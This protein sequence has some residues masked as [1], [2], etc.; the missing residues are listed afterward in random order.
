MAAPVIVVHYHELWLKGR[1]RKFFMGKLMLAL[2]R[3]LAD[4]PI[5]RFGQPGDRVLIHL[6]EGADPQ[7]ILA[8]LERVLGIAYMAVAQPVGSKAV[9]A[10]RFHVKAAGRVGPLALQMHN[11]G[12]FDEYANIAIEEN[13]K[14][15]ELI[16]AK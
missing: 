14:R 8:R 4:L 1:N 12:L 10:G 9:E 15:D 13:P 5:R 2:R 6:S 16:T 3:T 7:T 11:Q